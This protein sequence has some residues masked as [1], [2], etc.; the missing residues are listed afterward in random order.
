M[1]DLFGDTSSH[2]S[3]VFDIL[4]LISLLMPFLLPSVI[5]GLRECLTV[6]VLQLPHQLRT[7][8]SP[9]CAV[10]VWTTHK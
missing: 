6:D 4:Q 9:F 7:S 10:H 5:N 8:K 2:V 3:N 1:V